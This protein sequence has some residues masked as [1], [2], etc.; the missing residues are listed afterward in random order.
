M[1]IPGWVTSAG[2]MMASFDVRIITS[3]AELRSLATPWDDL[4]RRSRVTQPAAQAEPLAI[5]CEEFA[6]GATFRALVLR[7][8]ERMI[9]SLPLVEKRVGRYF[10]AGAL[11]NNPYAI[12]GTLAIDSEY[13]EEQITPL[14]A[15]ALRTLPW[16][17]FSL[18]FIN[19][20]APRWRSLARALAARGILADFQY[21]YDT[22][23]TDIPHDWQLYMAS[24]SGKLRNSIKKS[25]E[26][27]RDAGGGELKLLRACEPGEI[28]E[29]LRRG[30]EV[31][32]RSWK[33]RTGTSVLRTPGVFRFYCR[34]AQALAASG[35]LELV[36]LEHAGQAVAFLYGI[37]GKGIFYPP[38]IG[39]DDF[40]RF[41]AFAQSQTALNYQ[42]LEKFQQIPGRAAIDFHG[43]LGS[44]FAR[45]GQR[46]G[47]IAPA[48]CLVATSGAHEPRI[49]PLSIETALAASRRGT[50]KSGARGA[51][52]ARSKSIPCARRT[53]NSRRRPKS[54]NRSKS[55]RSH[56]AKLI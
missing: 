16:G 20:D 41:A 56:A 13:A 34:Q 48:R 39:Y 40:D 46:A 52:A 11:P 14:L 23:I 7:D 51:P 18:Q 26:R 36:F 2:E 21:A 28:E 49:L 22:G 44:G 33:S 53:K 29:V 19:I 8:G 10:R 45:Y 15:E 43:P 9:A 38:K 47:V 25:H 27:F 5:W 6:P 3:V 4:W 55:R 35:N 37:H 17:L 54:S 12:G 24:R 50:A 31:E 30:F 32:D 42:M 1:L